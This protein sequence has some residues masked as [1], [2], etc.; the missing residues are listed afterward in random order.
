MIR[1]RL[2]IAGRNGSKRLIFILQGEYDDASESVPGRVHAG[3]ADR[4]QRKR[5]K[6]YVTYD[7]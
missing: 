7:S 5:A 6:Q 3:G 1:L 4:N 2:K